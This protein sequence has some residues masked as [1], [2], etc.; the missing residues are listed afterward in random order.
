MSR[1]C[2]V[3]DRNVEVQQELQSLIIATSGKPKAS[4]ETTA[5][6]HTLWVRT[7]GSKHPGRFQQKV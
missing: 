2:S 6:L 4:N 7:I 3:T 1:L 5:G